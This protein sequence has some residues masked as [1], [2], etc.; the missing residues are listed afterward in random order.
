V[1]SRRRLIHG[2]VLGLIGLLLAVMV[3]PSDATA[4]RGKDP[5]AKKLE[6]IRER[7]EK[8][9]G[10]YVAGKPAEAAQTFEAG[11]KEYPYSAFLFNAGVC[12]QKLNDIQHALDRFREYV[13][14][15]PEA[16]DVAQVKQRIATLEAMLSAAAA[17]PEA[18]ADAGDAGLAEGGAPAVPTVAPPP[19]ANM[20]SLVV[21][22][23]EPPGAPLKL[24]AR[25]SGTGTFQ[26]GR[27][28][29]GWKEIAARSAPVSL[30]L[31]V[32]TYHL[33]VDKFRDFNRSETGLEVKPGH[34]YHFKANLSQ[35]AFM[36]FLRVSANV[37]GAY[38]YL[39]DKAKKRMAWGETP[40]GELVPAGK[41]ALLV[42]A[43]GFQPLVQDV[44][45]QQ[46]D[47]KELEVRLERVNYGFLRID[48]NAAEVKVSLDEQAVGVWRSGQPPLEVRAN[49]GRHRLKVTSPGRK[50]YEGDVEVPRGQVLPVRANMIPRYPR[51]AAWTQAA[52]GAVFLGAAIYFGAES[53]RLHNELEAD[54]KSGVLEQEDERVVR[55]RW[56][57]VGANA[58][59]VIGGAL[60]GLSIYNFIKDP[61]PESSSKQNKPVEF[62]DPSKAP[63]TAPA[64]AV[65][66][67]RRT[68]R[69]PLPAQRAKTR[70]SIVPT[71][72]AESG[73]VGVRG[74]F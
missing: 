60:A 27:D 11:Y 68:Q 6:A 58:G 70:V 13:R 46:G 30:T 45:V 32:G 3:L 21:V 17:V 64:A 48:S 42:E 43:P 72:G 63:P 66:P 18:G 74:S 67:S 40:H 7:M 8:G 15:D 31:D 9:Q 53:N 20:K 16:P 2:C 19:E 28:N 50:D 22:E 57:A 1:V 12:Y 34:V 41:H 61:L 65:D 69:A 38:V 24:Y 10:L 36:A 51:G 14:I 33:V 47:Q 71:F 44:T 23:T 55:G 4:Q 25:E 35:G 56:Y 54:R 52:V 37:R 29:P 49:S 62:D 26:A 73:G 59:F 39:D 5:L